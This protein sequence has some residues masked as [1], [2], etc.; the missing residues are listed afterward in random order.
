VLAI[1]I[2]PWVLPTT[3]ALVKIGLWASDS[4]RIDVYVNDETR[5]PFSQDLIGLEQRTYVF[6]VAAEDIHFL[7]VDLGKIPRSLIHVCEIS[8]EDELGSVAH[9]DGRVI[10]QNWGAVN[11]APAGVSEGCLQLQATTDSPI[12]YTKETIVLRRHAPAFLQDIVRATNKPASVVGIVTMGFA[13]LLMTGL[14][15]SGRRF[16]VWL[17]A[18]AL[19]GT[20]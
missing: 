5:P 18:M 12:L 9:F 6:Q 4:S 11:V 1:Y 8:I 3:A 17:G 10:S 13:L 19:V 14:L 2:L 16:H 7:R 20:V 15:R